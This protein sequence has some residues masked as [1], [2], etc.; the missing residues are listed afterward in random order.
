M[1]CWQLATRLGSVKPSPKVLSRQ[2]VARDWVSTQW[3]ILSKPMPLSIPVTQGVR[4]SMLMV[5]WL[6][7]TPRFFHA[8][9]ARWALDLPFLPRLLSLWW[10]ALLKMVKC[11][12]AGL[13]LNYKVRWKTQP[14]WV[15][16]PRALKWWTWCAM[17]LP[18]KRAC[19]KGISSPQWII[20]LSMM[21]IHWFKWS[22]VKHPTVWSIYKWCVIKRKAASMWP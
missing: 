16:T 19:K 1:W 12:A 11:T 10:M 21:P 18:P 4:W 3:K 6:V 14:S 17:V 5:S 9:A 20:N 2:Q 8:Q 13:G 15:M 22:H 7:S